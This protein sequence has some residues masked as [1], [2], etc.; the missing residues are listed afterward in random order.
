M[1][2]V[3]NNK[4]DA[5]YSQPWEVEYMENWCI[6]KIQYGWLK[7]KR[8]HESAYNPH[9]SCMNFTSAKWLS[10]STTHFE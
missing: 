2:I 6:L 4:K 1:Y 9:R 3:H 10:M 7:L 8:K 5:K